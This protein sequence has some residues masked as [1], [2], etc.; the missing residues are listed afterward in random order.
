MTITEAEKPAASQREASARANRIPL[1]QFAAFCLPSLALGI[2]TAPFFYVLPT[3]YAQH[4]QATLAALGT[5]LVV[6]R[7]FDAVTDPLIGWMTDKTTSPWGARKPWVVGGAILIAASIFA[8]FNPN[9]E[10]DVTYFL[11]LSLIFYLGW[12][13]FSLALDAWLTEITRDY[14][15]RTRL[16]G[17]QGLMSQAGGFMFF[18]AS[19]SGLFGQGMSAQLLSAVGWVSLV[20]LPGA[21]LTAATLAPSGVKSENFSTP[22]LRGLWTALRKNSALRVLLISQLFGG[23]G[24]GIYLGTQLLLLGSYFQ[25]AHNFGLIFMAYQAVHFIA[26]PLWLK[27]IYRF[28]KNRAW[29]V[30]WALAAAMTPLTLLVPPGEG[31]IVWLVLL[32]MIRSAVGGADIVAPRAL[33]ADAVDYGILKTSENAA[34]SYFA[35]WSLAVKFAAAVSSGVAFWLLA[36]IGFDPKPEAVNDGDAIVGLIA[37]GIFLPMVCNILAAGC[38]WLF[39]IDRRRADIIRRRIESRAARSGAPQSAS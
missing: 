30:S 33:M 17:W 16:S 13:M 36:M 14:N 1:V 19:V 21:A 2:I 6:S 27:I 4:T 26:M 18:G 20:V 29:A 39:P 12:T 23:F 28:G 34:G 31:A 5:A 7:L 3:F 8:L 38:I 24:G 35:A 37:I 11:V 25:Q 22:G 15:E 10:S 32:A 9:S